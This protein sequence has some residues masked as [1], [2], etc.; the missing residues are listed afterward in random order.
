M[1]LPES[2]AGYARVHNKA[3][4]DRI[5]KTASAQGLTAT[6]AAY[7]GPAKEFTVVV[8]SGAP[9]GESPDPLFEQLASQAQAD[10]TLTVDTFHENEQ[11]D[12]V[13]GSTTIC[14]P[15]TG[16]AS[17]SLCVWTDRQ[18]TGWILGLNIG[19]DENRA[20]VGDARRTIAG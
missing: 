11:F 2:I 5:A 8:L 20:L 17:G 12:R 19:V 6:G 3:E 7:H 1:R 13:D 9:P 15:V 16:A 4:E 18:F 10:E 14:A